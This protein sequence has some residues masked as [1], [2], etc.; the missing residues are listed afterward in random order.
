MTNLEELPALPTVEGQSF[1]IIKD[2]GDGT[3]QVRRDQ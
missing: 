1:T 3:Y 2:N